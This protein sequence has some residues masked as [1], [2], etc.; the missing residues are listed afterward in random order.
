MKAYRIMFLL[1]DEKSK[2]ILDYLIEVMPSDGYPMVHE[3]KVFLEKK[4]PNQGIA[5]IACIEISE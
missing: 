3:I 4:H 1:F 5:I 2:N